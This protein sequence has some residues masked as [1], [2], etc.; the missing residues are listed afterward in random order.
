MLFLVGK[1][2]KHTFTD[3]VYA[4]KVVSVVPGFCD[5]YN[6]KYENDTAIYVY[7]L[8]EDYRNGNIEIV[9]ERY[10]RVLKVQVF[11]DFI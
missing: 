7:Q 4:G 8:E 6:I 3:Q 2:V 11:V 9:V 10:T 1:Y 5:W